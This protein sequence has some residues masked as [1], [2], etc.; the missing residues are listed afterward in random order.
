MN[1]NAKE[2]LQIF[3]STC[4][5]KV[6]YRNNK[7]KNQH[8]ISTQDLNSLSYFQTYVCVCVC[9]D[10]WICHRKKSYSGVLNK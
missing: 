4:C 5:L 1:I 2:K 7:K 6:V 8:V 10:P 3:C 9:N